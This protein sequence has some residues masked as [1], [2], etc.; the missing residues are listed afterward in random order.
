MPGH[1]SESIANDPNIAKLFPS[2]DRL[3]GVM[4]PGLHS[5]PDRLNRI[6]GIL[7]DWEDDLL[8]IGASLLLGF[9]LDPSSIVDQSL[10]TDID[11][12]LDQIQSSLNQLNDKID[13]IIKM[14]Q[15]LPAVMAGVMDTEL[16]KGYISESLTDVGQIADCTP[17]LKTYAANQQN[18][19][20]IVL[21]L[22][23]AV[24]KVI[25]YCGN[26]VIAAT[27]TCHPIAIWAQTKALLLR[28]KGLNPSGLTIYDMSFYKSSK[29]F[30]QS[31]MTT[32]NAIKS[33]KQITYDGLPNTGVPSG[34]QKFASWLLD[35]AT[36][37]FS[38]QSTVDCSKEAYQAL[39]NSDALLAT[40]T[41]HEPITGACASLNVQLWN[42]P[43]WVDAANVAAAANLWPGLVPVRDQCEKVLSYLLNSDQ[44][45]A[46]IQK[47][48]P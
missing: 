19:I 12:K 40:T 22:E 38:G 46:A 31:M 5:S 2:L 41:L 32:V 23:R 3:G 28:D 18:V 10:L 4:F 1:R 11:G 37:K 43:V 30:M 25:A 44:A 27:V 9:D 34:H 15:D 24:N 33:E 48:M 16:A 13:S 26:T 6:Y 7:A 35:A 47:A 20:S 42:H 17:D 36:Q 39:S 21:D 45:F 8:S 14:L 29:Q